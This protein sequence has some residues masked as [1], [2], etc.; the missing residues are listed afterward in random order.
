MGAWPPGKVR[1]Y[2]NISS[3]LLSIEILVK[4]CFIYLRK[5]IFVSWHHLGGWFLGIYK[6]K[7][8]LTAEYICTDSNGL[9]KIATYPI[10]IPL[11]VPLRELSALTQLRQYSEYQLHWVWMKSCESVESHQKD[12]WRAR[13]SLLS[14][15]IFLKQVLSVW[16][17]GNA[18]HL[19]TPLG[20]TFML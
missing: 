19:P 9:E 5:K 12:I 17:E 11:A 14:A 18:S 2:F 7:R 13:C 3:N 15:M 1:G 8:I 16:S 4:F 6:G 20:G 10:L